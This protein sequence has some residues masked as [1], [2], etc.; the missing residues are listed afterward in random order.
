MGAGSLTRIQS[1]ARDRPLHVRDGALD[2][3]FLSHQHVH[4][5]RLMQKPA[6]M[7]ENAIQPRRSQQERIADSV[8]A[9][10]VTQGNNF[11]LWP[12]MNGIVDGD[13]TILQRDR[14]GGLAESNR[15]CQ[16]AHTPP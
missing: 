4:G 5:E 14:Y 10:E 12:E 2:D 6:G 13:L 16:I 3:S 9:A 8:H 15:L 1:K 11:G 7:E